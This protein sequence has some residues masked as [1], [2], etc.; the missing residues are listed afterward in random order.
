MT[1]I[2]GND[3]GRRWLRDATA[4]PLPEAGPWALK[5]FRK[6]IAASRARLRQRPDAEAD[7]SRPVSRKKGQPIERWPKLPESNAA[8]MIRTRQQQRGAAGTPVQAPLGGSEGG[9]YRAGIARP[10]KGSALERRDAVCSLADLRYPSCCCRNWCS[11]LESSRARCQDNCSLSV[12]LPF[13]HRLL[14]NPLVRRGVI[15]HT[16][17]A[18]AHP[19][20]WMKARHSKI[21]VFL[22]HCK[23]N[24]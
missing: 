14:L 17:V 20:I 11:K 13:P 19:H 15:W 1:F 18:R 7:S 4:L 21:A 16:E 9:G 12:G 3:H 10:T 22:G 8:P 2:A 5:T 6:N 23:W 24:R